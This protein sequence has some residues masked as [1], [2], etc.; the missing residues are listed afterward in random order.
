MLLLSV[1]TASA[2]MKISQYPRTNAFNPGALILL[3]TTNGTPTNMSMTLSNLF[4]AGGQQFYG[5]ITT[6]GDI[7]GS[8]EP[9]ISGIGNISMIDLTAQHIDGSSGWFQA[10]NATTVV[11]LR[12]KGLV[13]MGTNIFEVVGTNNMK[14]MEIRQDGVTVISIIEE[15]F[16]EPAATFSENLSYISTPFK[17]TVDDMDI[18]SAGIESVILAAG[19]DGAPSVTCHVDGVRIDGEKLTIEPL[20]DSGDYFMIRPDGGATHFHISSTVAVNLP[21]VLSKRFV[22]TPHSTVQT[23]AAGT[24]LTNAASTIKVAGSGGAVSLTS[25]PNILTNNV[26]DGEILRIVGTHD[27]NTLTVQDTSG[28][29]GSACELGNAT[30]ALGNNDVLTLMWNQT[31]GKWIEIGFNNN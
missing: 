23:V 17:V 1:F 2:Q 11:P 16:S 9:A 28:V 25:E 10:T 22:V 27:T 30:R 12:A 21:L 24:S 20:S 26:A 29:A 5:G 18:I 14:V 15:G 31:S 8:G 7:I 4:R 13:G 3:A 6:Y 19:D